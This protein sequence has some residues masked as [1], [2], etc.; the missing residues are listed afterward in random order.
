MHNSL[1]SRLTLAFGVLAMAGIAG[2]ASGQEPLTSSS[3]FTDEMIEKALAEVEANPPGEFEALQRDI[4]ATELL[5]GELS[6][7]DLDLTGLDLTVYPTGISEAL[8]FVATDDKSDALS[9]EGWAEQFVK[10]LVASQVI[11]DFDVK[12]LAFQ[13]GGSDE[14]GPFVATLT[15]LLSDLSA[16]VS[17]G[18]NV[19]DHAA[20]QMERP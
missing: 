20:V 15:I 19:F 5:I 6:A 3:G 9:A 16:A 7:A 12:R 8:L 17:S 11:S 10:A 2:A 1:L 13:Y 18:G 14:Q 4:I